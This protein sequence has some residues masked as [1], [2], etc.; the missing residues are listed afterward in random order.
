MKISHKGDMLFQAQIGH[1]TVT[2]DVSVHFGGNDRA[3][4]PPEYF[5]FSLGSCCGAMLA[6]WCYDNDLDPDDLTVEVD[7]EKGP[8]GITDIKVTVDLP[9]VDVHQRW[10][11]IA[12]VVHTCPVHKSLY[13]IKDCDVKLAIRRKGDI[14]CHKKDK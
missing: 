1:H 11:E 9:G 7:Y 5:I 6:G 13:Q 12:Q 4:T 2:A 10:K 8:K 3:V 14:T